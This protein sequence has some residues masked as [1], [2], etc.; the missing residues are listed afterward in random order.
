MNEKLKIFIYVFIFG[1]LIY[2]LDELSFKDNVFAETMAVCCDRGLCHD[3]NCTLGS[4]MHISPDPINQPEECYEYM[5][6]CKECI[7][8]EVSH[9]V[10]QT[11]TNVWCN[12]PD[13][14]RYYG[15]QVPCL[16]QK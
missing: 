12:K 11:Y 13:Q 6:T 3:N 4:S 15:T 16:A 9:C 7:D 5:F 1:T 14:T 10:C 8:Y 2:G